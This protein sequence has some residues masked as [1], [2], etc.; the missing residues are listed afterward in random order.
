[1][2]TFEVL[3]EVL[4]HMINGG[5]AQTWLDAP[6]M[7]I[8]SKYTWL[9]L[10]L[11][12]LVVGA[13]N[14]RG[15]L[16]PLFLL[17]GI[18]IGVTDLVTYQVV[19]PFIGRERPCRQLSELRMVPVWCGGDYGMPSNHAANGMAVTVI[20]ALNAPPLAAVLALALTLITGFSRVYLGVHFPGDVLA[21]MVFGAVV[22]LLCHYLFWWTFAFGKRLR[23]SRAGAAGS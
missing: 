10:A 19:K 16:L 6:M 11:V 20:L 2:A 23:R 5:L 14:R 9:A 4:F 15:R 22:G 3:D 1:M 18:T 13:L 8:S 12:V 7:F 21:G 17:L